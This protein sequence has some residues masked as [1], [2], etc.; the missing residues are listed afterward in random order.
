MERLIY[1]NA[2]AANSISSVSTNAT[3]DNLVG[4]GRI[5]DKA[6]QRGGRIL[7]VQLSRVANKAGFGPDAIVRKIEGMSSVTATRCGRLYGL[8][9]D[10]LLSLKN[11]TEEEL[12]K[13][14]HECRKLLGYVT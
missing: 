10:Q 2:R 3:A 8:Y 12:D 11:L 6:Y 4:P 1:G 13:V 14:K 9:N 5:L 7:E